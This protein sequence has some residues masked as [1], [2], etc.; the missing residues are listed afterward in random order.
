M[1]MKGIIIL[2]MGVVSF[3]L[4]LHDISADHSEDPPSKMFQLGS[5]ASGS[6]FPFSSG[7]CITGVTADSSCALSLLSNQNWSSR[8]QSSDT[9]LGNSM[10]IGASIP[11]CTMSHGVT[12]AQLPSGGSSSSS[13]WGFKGNN[14]ADCGFHAMPSAH[15]GPGQI[16]QPLFSGQYNVDHLMEHAQN[17]GRQYMD[18]D[19]SRAY[20]SANANH[21]DW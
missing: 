11:Q 21:V 18:V 4:T 10:N 2:V 12:V 17:G 9:G 5:A 13:P 8:N 20:H 15:L 7:E 16:S 1:C 14:D 6:N 19:H 3:F